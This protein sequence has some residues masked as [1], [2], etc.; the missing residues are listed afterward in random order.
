M[1]PRS[2]IVVGFMLA[3]AT[4][5]LI[6]QEAARGTIRLDQTQRPIKVDFVVTESS[7]PSMTQLGVLEIEGDVLRLHINRGT[8][9]RPTDFN[10]LPDN[11]LIV[12]RRN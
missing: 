8:L 1:R 5:H 7:G 10:P 11:F 9:L 4:F 2:M 12:A 3:M 6:G